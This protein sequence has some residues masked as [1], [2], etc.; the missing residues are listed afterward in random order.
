ML[1]YDKDDF[2]GCDKCDNL[3]ADGTC[4]RVANGEGGRR[5]GRS[6]ESNADGDGS[7]DFGAV[8]LG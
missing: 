6:D 2:F 7:N 5:K 4:N 1:Y 3:G 8:R